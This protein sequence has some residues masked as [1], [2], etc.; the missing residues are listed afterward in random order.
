MGQLLG[1]EVPALV[2]DRLKLLSAVAVVF[3]DLLQRQVELFV[4]LL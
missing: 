1:V 3:D 2:L 4:I